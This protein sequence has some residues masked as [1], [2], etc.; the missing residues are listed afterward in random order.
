M[1]GLILKDFLVMR[2]TLKTYT[3]FLIFYAALAALGALP[4]ATVTAMVQII[5]IMLPISAF[6]YDEFAKWDRY[7]LT[8][9]LGRRTVVKARYLF[10]LLMTLGAAAFGLLA[11]VLL[12]LFRQESLRENLAS[13]LMCLALGLFIADVMLP[14]CYKLGPERARPYLYLLVFLPV[15]LL[16]I[17]YKLGFLNGLELFFL[18][19]LSEGAIL[20]LFALLPLAALAGLWVSYLAACRVVEAKEF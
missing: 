1:T 15:I 19:D 5:L 9:P 12:S 13:V 8:L 6:S 4:L 2:K 14:L 20:A 3:L 10:T 17:T 7:V 11:C 18:S 16:F